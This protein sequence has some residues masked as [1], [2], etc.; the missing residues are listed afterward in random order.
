[1]WTP[2]SVESSSIECL[3]SEVEAHGRDWFE[4][5]APPVE[6]HGTTQDLRI[7]D[8]VASQ[9]LNAT[10]RCI[11]RLALSAT[12]ASVKH[13][14]MATRA[15]LGESA[16]DRQR[17]CELIA[18][19]DACGAQGAPRGSSSVKGSSSSSNSNSEPVF[20]IAAFVPDA[21]NAHLLRLTARSV[22][23]LH[24]AS[25]LLV[26]DNAAPPPVATEV[27]RDLADALP[28]A[29]TRCSP[30]HEL[31]ATW[32]GASFSPRG[33]ASPPLETHW[34]MGH[35]NFSLVSRS[36]AHYSSRSR[37]CEPSSYCAAVEVVRFQGVAIGKRGAT[38]L[39]PGATGHSGREYALLAFVKPWMRSR[40]VTSD[41]VVLLQHSTGLR[42]PIPFASTPA[43]C[44]A[45][46]LFVP[47]TWTK[48]AYTSLRAL[49]CLEAPYAARGI[50]KAFL[51]SPANALW[52]VSS[53]VAM[54][55][56]TEVLAKME[57]T[58][59]FEPEVTQ[60]CLSLSCLHTSPPPLQ[61]PHCSIHALADPAIELSP[62]GRLPL[63]ERAR[64]HGDRRGLHCGMVCP[65]SRRGRQ[66][67]SRQRLSGS[68][69]AS[70]WRASSWRACTAS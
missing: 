35:G 61:A 13:G 18:L 62:S 47:Y 42:A 64:M 52:S 29:S 2:S 28:C 44:A 41:F 66:P 23:A 38:K 20:V 34:A 33:D 14:T 1:M 32:P 55:L 19:P 57:E 68:R 24:P 46:A 45:S 12:D 10:A 48:D 8:G 40:G 5:N 30:S 59:L 65:A 6:R 7:F 56:R 50:A 58:R 15:S 70:G 53:N 69:R 63:G 22:R 9:Q 37:S 67:L 21:A 26:L 16:A 39:A 36:G 25:P 3:L 31:G 49:A 27:F 11:E 54:Y 43:R 4:A 60:L 51:R 17:L